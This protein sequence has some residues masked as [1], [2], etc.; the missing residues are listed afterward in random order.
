MRTQS[1]A[2]TAL[3]AAEGLPA[4]YRDTVQR[5]WQPLAATIAVVA[6]RAGQ[7]LIVGINGSQGSGKSTLCRFL[8]VL[9]REGHRFNAAT[10]SLDDL[11]L[12]R[13]ERT[14]LAATVH[15][16]LATR[17]VPGTHDVALGEAVLA[18][19]RQGR[20]G[21]RLPRFDKACD[22][23]APEAG[24]PA[25]TAPIDVLLFEG[26]CMA[27]APQTPA[28][29]AA[30][31]NTLEADE[32]ADGAWRAYVNAALEGPYRALFA[33]IDFLV[34]L[35]TPGF[36]AVLGWRQEQERNLRERKGG[37]MADSEVAR[38]VMHYER[39]TRH[40][41]AELPDRADMVVTL[42]AD[43]AVTAV[44]HAE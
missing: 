43:H 1:P 26:W 39:L 5:F 36:E 22:D 35:A 6:A 42:G 37:G 13:R 9:L 29:L 16:L 18:A 15:P 7:P 41:L 14:Q 10:L 40:L 11:Y 21:L 44:R 19:V 33:E 32:D 8:E 3:I 30:P 38:F 34:M 31:I 20:A 4:A 23:R 24:W 17:G 27:A 28:D 12:T 25:I 2:I